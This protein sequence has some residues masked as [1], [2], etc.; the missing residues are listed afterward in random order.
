MHLRSKT[1]LFPLILV[2]ATSLAAC[3]SRQSASD[4]SGN[5][6]TPAPNAGGSGSPGEPPTATGQLPGKLVGRWRGV[7]GRGSAKT[8]QATGTATV[9][10]DFGHEVK[11]FEFQVAPDG[12]I[13]GSGEAAYWFD[14]TSDA[15]LL[16]IRRKDAANLEGGRQTVAFMIEGK[17]SPDGRVQLSSVIQQQLSLIV[18]GKKQGMNAWNVFGPEEVSRGE[19]QTP[20]GREVQLAL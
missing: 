12:T 7:S 1:I 20:G 15:D 11:H 14:V 19:A 8:S 2:C 18:D 17:M 3:T 9:T 5:S 6:G 13:T 4:P 10:K 16:V